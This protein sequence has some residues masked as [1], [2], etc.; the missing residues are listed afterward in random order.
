MMGTGGES[1]QTRP[2]PAKIASTK[3]RMIFSP[4]IRLSWLVAHPRGSE[5]AIRSSLADQKPT[6][7][8]YLDLGRGSTLT[9]ANQYGQG[10]NQLQNP[11][12]APKF[13]LFSID[14]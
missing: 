1:D 3:H 2:T 10:P 5:E 9:V 11:S 6:T 7:Y 8:H 14:R 12:T 13:A 4:W